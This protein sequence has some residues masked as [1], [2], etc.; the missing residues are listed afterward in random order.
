MTVRCFSTSLLPVHLY[1]SYCSWLFRSVVYYR[2]FEGG[3]TVI[4]FFLFIRF[5]LYFFASLCVGA[6]VVYPTVR[7][8]PT[9]YVCYF[10]LPYLFFY[11]FLIVVLLLLHSHT[12]TK[13]HRKHSKKNIKIKLQKHYFFIYYYLLFDIYFLLGSTDYG[14]GWMTLLCSREQGESARLWGLLELVS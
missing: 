13:K 10:L 3:W 9:S 11:L 8:L 6:P 1:P 7:L 14:R 2:T 4:V 5:L 12:H